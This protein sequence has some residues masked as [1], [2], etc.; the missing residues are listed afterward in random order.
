VRA[1]RL[2]SILLLLQN[3]G[4]M[5]SAQLAKRL[6]VSDRTVHRDMSALGSAGVPV[7]ADRGAGG[8]WSLM[9]GYRA[10]ISALNE[11]EVRA[12]FVGTPASLLH[13][14]HLDRAS[15]DAALKLLSVLPA[16]TRR[17]AEVARQRIHIDLAGWKQS[18][19]PVPMLPIIQDAVWS[20]RKLRFEYNGRERLADPMGLVAKGSVWYLVAK[21]EGE[22]RTYRVSRITNAAVLD[23][24]SESPRDFDLGHY[25]EQAATEFK[26]KLPR[27]EVVIRGRLEPSMQALIRYGAI[28]SIEEDIVKM[29][30]DAEFVAIATL[31]GFGDAVEVLEP[32]ELREKLAAAAKAVIAR[33]AT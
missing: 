9:E 1:D 24:P 7:V 4:R 2:V 11:A 18:R 27:Y 17:A 6:Q 22:I 20:A 14:L 3:H 29:H 30:F 33:Y 8:G 26:E 13:D 12:L 28:D 31:L 19:D 5:T 15:D 23:E 32:V 25:W 10:K 16:V 21:V